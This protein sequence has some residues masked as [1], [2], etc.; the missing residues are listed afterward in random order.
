ML[1]ELRWKVSASATCLHAAACQAAGVPKANAELATAL[2]AAAEALVAEL[3]S[4]GWPLQEALHA[5]AGLASEVGNNRQLVSRAAARLNPTCGDDATLV[6][7]AGA[8]SDLEAAMRRAQP[9][10]E[11][12]MAVRIGPIREQWEARGPGM[13]SEVSRLADEA[14]VPAAA[15][16]VLVAPYAG[17]HGLAH[18]AHNRVTFEAVLVNPIA[19]LPEVVR[20]AWLISQLNS[21]LPRYS[22]VLPAGRSRLLMAFATIPPVLAAAEAVE[23]A[24]YSEATLSL[25]LSAWRLPGET[26]DLIAAKLSSWWDA[27]LNLPKSWPVA[28]AA[29]ERMLLNG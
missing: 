16:I 24:R 11:E 26:P 1:E 27:W 9:Q 4:A 18:A 19:E 7:L 22:D 14:A 8:I 23:L 21:D 3:L 6:R 12:E 28:M 29:L 17:G 10:L 5:L 2:D 20:L 13:L 15:E 25:A